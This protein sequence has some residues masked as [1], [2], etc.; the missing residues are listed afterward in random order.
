MET[1]P[2]QQGLIRL[3]VI[4]IIGILILSYFGFDIQKTVESE[5]AQKNIGYTKA[6]V[7]TVWHKYL[8]APVKYLWDL[9]IEFLWKPAFRN[10]KNFRDGKTIDLGQPPP[11]AVPGT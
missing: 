1:I 11:K 8:E 6:L 3:L 5:M 2:K 4:I 9:F 10:L 7:L